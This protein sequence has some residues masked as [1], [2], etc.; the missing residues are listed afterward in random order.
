M[1]KVAMVP[2]P[3]MLALLTLLMML[4]SCSQKSPPYPGKRNSAAG[5]GAS[6]QVAASPGPLNQRKPNPN[7]TVKPG[8]ADASPSPATASEATLALT[9]GDDKTWSLKLLGVDAG[10][11]YRMMEVPVAPVEGSKVFKK[12]GL[13]FS[14]TEDSGDFE[15]EFKIGIKQGE[16]LEVVHE[17][18]NVAPE[19]AQTEEKDIYLKIEPS[20]SKGAIRLTIAAG[21]GEQLFN[22]L[23]LSEDRIK[24]F[25]PVG[26]SGPG[27]RKIG[28][29]I[30]CFKFVEAA[31]GSVPTY[32][33]YIHF[34]TVKG[35]VDKA[36][37]IVDLL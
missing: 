31:E 6:A 19:M 25:D 30:K 4:T 5:T 27:T 15:C 7:P 13:Q 26:T 34:N 22:A 3:T 29:E 23:E 10:K 35:S 28:D 16:V 36:S 24:N 18:K 20:S 8:S 17:V 2:Y 33:C 37:P 9:K 11:V 12:Q 14:C 32:P 1:Y 21:F